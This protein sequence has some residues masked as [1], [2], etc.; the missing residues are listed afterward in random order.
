MYLFIPVCVMKNISLYLLHKVDQ[1]IEKLD[2]ILTA[3]HRLKIVSNT[4]HVL[5]HTMT[6]SKEILH[7]IFVGKQLKNLIFYLV[8]T[9]K[10]YYFQLYYHYL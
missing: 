6:I 2:S 9:E 8:V 1:I 5:I 4:K 3:C 10:N 7:N